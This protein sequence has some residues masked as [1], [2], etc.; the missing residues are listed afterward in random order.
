MVPYLGELVRALFGLV[1]LQARLCEKEKLLSAGK[2]GGAGLNRQY[3]PQTKLICMLA[4]SGR[5]SES[6][7]LNLRA[8]ARGENA[9]PIP[10]DCAGSHLQRLGPCILL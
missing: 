9:D 10:E 5:P 2:W 3:R 8:H 4:K 7:R 6:E 1:G